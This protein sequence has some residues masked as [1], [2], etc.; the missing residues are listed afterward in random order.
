MVSPMEETR[1]TAKA[2][3]VIF[4]TKLMFGAAELAAGQHPSFKN[5]QCPVALLL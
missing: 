2:S 5:V 4:I 3:K 1:P